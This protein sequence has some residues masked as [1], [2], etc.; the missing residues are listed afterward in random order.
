MYLQARR[1]DL[2]RERRILV[3]LAGCEQCRRMKLPYP[4]NTEITYA[5]QQLWDRVNEIDYELTQINR[6]LE[7]P[8]VMPPYNVSNICHRET[9]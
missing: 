6:V 5:E 3:Y 1:D 4:N 8:D 7:T 9:Y 2:L